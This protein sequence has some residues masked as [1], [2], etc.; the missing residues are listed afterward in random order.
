[1][2]FARQLSSTEIFEQAQKFAAELSQKNERLSNVVLMVSR[3]P[4]II[5]S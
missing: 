2:G 1:M 5:E 4:K 3:L